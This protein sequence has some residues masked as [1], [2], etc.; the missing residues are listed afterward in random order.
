V[1]GGC[2]GWMGDMPLPGTKDLVLGLK[3]W[4]L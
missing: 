4:R 3:A 1:K 2:G